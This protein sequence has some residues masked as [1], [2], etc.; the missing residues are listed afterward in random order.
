M[1][2]FQPACRQNWSGRANAGAQHIRRVVM[3]GTRAHTYH[4]SGIDHRSAS[5]MDAGTLAHLLW[6]GSRVPNMS[7]SLPGG[8]GKLSTPR[9]SVRHVRTAL[10]ASLAQLANSGTLSNGEAGAHQTISTPMR[11]N[12]RM[13]GWISPWS[14][15]YSAHGLKCVALRPFSARKRPRVWASLGY[16]MSMMRF[17]S[18]S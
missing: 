7:W 6:E 10:R 9:V 11:L 5:A 17:Q 12:S 8:P 1:E 3:A 18:Q 4:D 2:T 13:L 15:R 16:S 14:H